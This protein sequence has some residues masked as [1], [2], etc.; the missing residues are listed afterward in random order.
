MGEMVPILREQVCKGCE[1]LDYRYTRAR[2]RT[3]IRTAAV[4][5]KRHAFLQ[6][7]A[8]YYAQEHAIY[9]VLYCTQ[10]AVERSSENA[11][12]PDLE[13]STV[14]V[15]GNIIFS[16]LTKTVATCAPCK[17]H[18]SAAKQWPLHAHN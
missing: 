5:Q 9:Y 16:I 18:M 10:R 3:R 13:P 1:G 7:H 14:G 12:E 6:E 8:I 11:A 17:P 4:A 2:A 15:T